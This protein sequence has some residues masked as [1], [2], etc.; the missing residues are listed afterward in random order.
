MLSAAIAAD[1]WDEQDS[2]KVE[3]LI[4]GDSL[5]CQNLLKTR[6]NETFV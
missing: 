4:D 1:D 2:L 5:D 3:V 6:I